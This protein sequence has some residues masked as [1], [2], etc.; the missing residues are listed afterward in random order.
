MSATSI[1]D[2]SP[3]KPERP[4]GKPRRRRKVILVAGALLVGALTYPAVELS[5]VPGF[6][7][8]CHVIEPAHESWQRS[9]HYLDPKTKKIRATCR[10]CH[11]P[12]WKEPW[13]VIAV[14]LEHGFGDTYHNL[15][16]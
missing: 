15:A 11:V 14:K 1:P 6:C 13:A 5:S 10:D 16:G 3:K 9:A 12:S 2:E 7:R 8:S 4:A